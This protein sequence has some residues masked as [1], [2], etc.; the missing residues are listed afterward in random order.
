IVYI[1]T[2]GCMNLAATVNVVLYD[3]LAKGEHFSHHQD[4][5][6]NKPK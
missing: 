1:P 3:R 2:K 6:R 4:A 5:F